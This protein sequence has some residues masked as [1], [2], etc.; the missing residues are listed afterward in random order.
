[1]PASATHEAILD[2]HM[3]S[4]LPIE[5]RILRLLRRISRA[6]DVHSRQLS[7]QQGL[8]GPQLVCMR[9]LR[10][11][12]RMTP[13]DLAKKISVSQA[14]VTGILDRLEL[15]GL[16]HRERNPDDKRRVHVWLTE[17]GLEAVSVAPQPLQTRFA[18]RLAGV[19]MDEQ[20]R[21]ERALERI[22]EMMEVADEMP[23]PPE[24]EGR[25]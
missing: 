15:R 1:M 19:P 4:D 22:V 13:S 17:R 12:G 7:V 6:V 2:L 16:V 25:S 14:T 5:E 11:S 3:E 9:E 23:P 10:V 20:E 8:T 24:P 21:I 18:R